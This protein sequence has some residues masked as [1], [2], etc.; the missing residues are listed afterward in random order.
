ME[1]LSKRWYWSVRKLAARLAGVAD[2]AEY[3]ARWLLVTLI[4]APPGQRAGCQCKGWSRG[5]PAAHCQSETDIGCP[6]ASCQSD[7]AP[8]VSQQQA[9]LV[10]RER[11]KRGQSVLVSSVPR[12]CLL[13]LQSLGQE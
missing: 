7:A 12:R 5:C 1:V 13:P 9:R 8:L 6:A 11:R 2:T 10:V 3:R 4:L